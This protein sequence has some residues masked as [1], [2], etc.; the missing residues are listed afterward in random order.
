MFDVLELHAKLVANAR[1][2]GGE[3]TAIAK[4]LAE[5]AAPFVDEVKTDAMGNLICHKKGKG[6]RVMLA[7][8]MDAIGFMVTG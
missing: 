3:H 7:A 1:P 6:K 8:H 4:V 2:S 5:L